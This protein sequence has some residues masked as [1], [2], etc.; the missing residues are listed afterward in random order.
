[1][2]TIRASCC[3][4]LGLRAMA[5][6][7]DRLQVVQ[8]IRAAFCL[9][10]NVVD[11]F[12]LADATSSATQLAQVHVTR[13]HSIALATPWPTSA[14]FAIV[15]RRGLSHMH[16]RQLRHWAVAVRK[17][18]HQP[19]L[20]DWSRSP[21]TSSPSRLRAGSSCSSSPSAASADSRAST[22]SSSRA[23]ARLCSS[24]RSSMRRKRSDRLTSRPLIRPHA[25]DLEAAVVHQ[26]P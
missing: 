1:M 14:S 9:R 25:L 17:P 15:L 10:H 7:A 13:H 12:C 23:V 21:G 26:F 6:A 2:R 5:F 20:C 3:L 22:F 11:L 24:C 4:C 18:R 16:R 8:R 19:R